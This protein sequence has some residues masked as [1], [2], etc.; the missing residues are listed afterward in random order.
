M[1]ITNAALQALRT[2]V[3]GEFATQLASLQANPIYKALASV[4]TSNTASNTYGWLGAFPQLREWVGDRV[5]KDIAESAYQ[6]IN[7]KYE[8]TL[9]VMRTAIEDDN[10]GQYRIIAAEMADE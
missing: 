2:M 9:G 7:E 3:R 8:A 1:I 5:I 4:I 10:L 6:I